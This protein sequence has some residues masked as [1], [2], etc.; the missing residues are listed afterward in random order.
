L[1]NLPSSAT[2]GTVSFANF[3]NITGNANLSGSISGN[4]LT[5]TAKSGSVDVGAGGSFDANFS[6]TPTVIGPLVNP[7]SGGEAMVDPNNDITEITKTN[8]SASET[9]TVTGIDVKITETDNSG[10]QAMTP[11]QVILYTLT[12]Q[13]AGTLTATGVTITTAVPAYTTFDAADSSAGWSGV[14]SGSPGGTTATFNAGT[15]SYASGSHT[16]TFAVQVVNPLPAGISKQITSQA[17]ISDDG[18]NGPD[19]NPSNNT[20]SDTITLNAAPDLKITVDDG[21]TTALPGT[22]LDYTLAYSNIGNQGATGVVLTETLPANT[23]FNAAQSSPGWTS[24]GSGVYTLVVGSLAGGGAGGTVAFAVTVNSPL[25]ATVT[26]ISNTA[27]I[28]DDHANGA[29]PTPG[30]NSATHSDT[31]PYVF[32]TAPS[33]Y[34]TSLAQNGARH[35]V[36]GPR[37]GSTVTASADGQP[38]TTGDA[39]DDGVTFLSPFVADGTAA[40]QVNVQNAPSGAKLDVWIDWNHNGSW[41]DTGEEVVTDMPVVNGNNLLT[42]PVPASAAV[43]AS[44]TTDARFR[45]STAGG[46]APT[47]AAP[48]GEVEDYAVKLL[49]AP[50]TVYVNPAFTGTPGTTPTGNSGATAIGYDAF[51]T[52]QAAVN[53]VASGG[54]VVIA[55]GNYAED[56]TV[57]TSVTLQGANADG[58]GNGGVSQLTG[59]FRVGASNVDIDGLT[60]LGGVGPGGGIGDITAIWLKPGSSNDTIT[61]NTLTGNGNGTAILTTSN[62]V[63]LTI[64]N[65][66][67]SGWATGINNQQDTGVTIQNNQIS[68]NT[69]GIADTSVTNLLV[70]K[71]TITNNAQG[72]TIT[73]GTNLT[74]QNDT[75][76]GNTTDALNDLGSS[77]VNAT[78]DF[79]GA[80]NG[81]TTAANPGGTGD[82]LLM[83]I[84]GTVLFQPFVNSVSLPFADTFTQSNGT[85]LSSAWQLQQGAFRAQNDQITSAYTNVYGVAT[86]TNLKAINATVEADVTMTGDGET[87]L[88]T[89]YS[90]SS[91]ANAQMYWA[92]V[93][94]SSGKSYAEIWV[95]VGGQ[96]QL[97]TV[98]PVASASGHYLFEDTNSLLQL[99]VNGELAGST[100]NATLT[101][102]GSV[103]L[104]AKPGTLIDNFQAQAMPY[105]Q[106]VLPADSFTQNNGAA[107]DSAWSPVAGSFSVQN[108]QLAA[109][110]AGENLAIANNVSVA[111]VAVQADVTVANGS[112]LGLVARS[113][114]A[115]DQNMYWGGISQTNGQTS[116]TIWLKHNGTWSLLNSG[117]TLPANSGTLRFEVLGSSLKL[118]WNGQLTMVAH[119]STLTLPG[120]VGLWASGSATFDNFQG[121]PL[122]TQ[123][124][125]VPFKDQFQQ[126]SGTDLSTYWHETAGA[127]Q[128][129]NG[130]AT[131]FGGVS[132]ALV[133]GVWLQNSAVTAN[134]SLQTSGAVGVVARASTDGR[135]MYWAGITYSGG[136]YTASIWLLFNGTWYQLT[137][138]T[139]LS[140]SYSGSGALRFVVSGNSLSLSVNGSL[141]AQA[142][143]SNLTTG[144]VGMWSSSVNSLANF[145]VAAV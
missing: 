58:K 109:K 32:G 89:Q 35:I 26:T 97:L 69:V 70:Q 73:S 43:T 80:Y 60:I 101:A 42:I 39:D 2:Y 19:G 6:V 135:N 14:A 84:A 139:S 86:L 31:V 91:A 93:A 12:Y 143:D 122:V 117:V 106:N 111:D 66:I 30:D 81:P 105:A 51:A 121:T 138:P 112:S 5:V 119:D 20:S 95:R 114:G 90:G 75:F 59:G 63:N 140:G 71:N 102:P 126:G 56:V 125:M 28:A 52:I 68:N 47:G 8:N 38:S 62:N 64:T 36:T 123:N 118:F 34:P 128:V 83:A 41:S 85:G 10:G 107:L 136:Q 4:N 133:N 113:S 141:V 137:T 88:V 94:T 87:G 46:L 132:T 24:Q 104:W 131:N 13:E 23:T 120:T 92:G 115:D 25:A 29:D 3:T 45:L 134:V 96:W 127:F 142:F 129:Q 50:T 76:G 124:A 9:I 82:A 37:L 7:S 77:T 21:Q 44:T 67:I 54:T 144:T 40:I 11:G 130:Q 78:N 110:A 99:F 116:V 72:V 145:G 22:G 27:S 61:Y 49:P 48:D 55:A 100:M 98:A 15:L 108:G 1:D 65:N 53:V 57:N 18:T 33:P 17:S 103:G 74:I 79:W 16:V